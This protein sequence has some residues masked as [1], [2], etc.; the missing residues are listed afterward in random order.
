MGG[1]E[2]LNCAHSDQYVFCELSESPSLMISHFERSLTFNTMCYIVHML[3]YSH[4][5]CYDSKLV[6]EVRLTV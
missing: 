1:E 4:Y 3:L 6:N 5:S 2:R